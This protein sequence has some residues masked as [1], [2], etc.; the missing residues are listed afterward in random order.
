MINRIG[1]ARGWPPATRAQ[2]ERE[3]GP[4]GALC[5]G[6]P[7]TVASKIVQ[8]ARLLDLS[9]FN[10]KYSAGT[11]PHPLL[12]KSIELIGTHVAPRVREMMQGQNSSTGDQFS[13]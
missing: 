5:V 7:E 4:D 10:L 2:F 1:G 8:T 11:L 12:M 13:G 9:R 6:S 3:A